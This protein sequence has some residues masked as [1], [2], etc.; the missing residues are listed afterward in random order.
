V[1]RARD[2][3][4]AGWLLLA[5]R[6]AGLGLERGERDQGVAEAAVR[7]GEAE[8]VVRSANGDRP[9]RS[10]G[11]C[12]CGW[13]SRPESDTSTRPSRAAASATASTEAHQRPQVGDVVVELEHQRVEPAR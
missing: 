3:P 1:Q 9:R 12:A 4:E 2:R 5:Q 6:G 8:E 13:C 10:S 11:S 7:V